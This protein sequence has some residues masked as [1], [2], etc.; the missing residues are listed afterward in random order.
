MSGRSTEQIRELLD[1]L[2][3][4]HGDAGTRVGVVAVATDSERDM[5]CSWHHVGFGA[6]HSVLVWMGDFAPQHI[7]DQSLRIVWIT[8]GIGLCPRTRVS[9]PGIQSAAL[10]QIDTAPDLP[11][12]RDFLLVRTRDDRWAL[13]VFRGHDGLHPAGDLFR[14]TGS[15]QILWQCVSGVPSPGSHADSDRKAIHRKAQHIGRCRTK[16]LSTIAQTNGGPKEPSPEISQ[17]PLTA[18]TIKISDPE[19][20]GLASPPVY[21]AF[22]SPMKMLMC[23]RTCPCSV[24]MRSRT[25]G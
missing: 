8:T 15:Y 22:S 18:G 21:R 5:G 9:P 6:G 17:P 12:I 24:A 4:A 25:P 1:S 23:S 11:G 3:R 14:R 2:Y 10:L 7:S 19:G 16:N 20:T 13:A